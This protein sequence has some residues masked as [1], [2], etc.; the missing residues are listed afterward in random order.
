MGV[1]EFETNMPCLFMGSFDS[2]TFSVE[3]RLEMEKGT[4][5]ALSEG[6]WEKRIEVALPGGSFEPAGIDDSQEGR[7]LESYAVDSFYHGCLSGERVTNDG[8]ENLKTLSAVDAFIRSSR[9]SM[10]EEV[11]RL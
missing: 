6:S 9:A 8:R 4:V 5:R 10:R 1:L 7:A 3:I 11:R 2:R